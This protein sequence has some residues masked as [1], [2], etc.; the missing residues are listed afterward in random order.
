MLF[1][2]CVTA[3]AVAKHMDSK[4]QVKARPSSGV[5]NS[6]VSPTTGIN[7]RVPDPWATLQYGQGISS[8]VKRSVLPLGLIEVR[9]SIDLQCSSPSQLE[10][11]I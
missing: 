11:D 9:S 10:R 5:I 4:Q 1:Q 2:T 3:S 6:T 8:Q 7:V